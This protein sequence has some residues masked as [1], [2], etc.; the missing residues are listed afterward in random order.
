MVGKR[1]KDKP[2]QSQS[3]PLTHF[4]QASIG[5]SGHCPGGHLL[6]LQIENG[7][8]YMT[9]WGTMSARCSLSFL[10]PQPAPPLGH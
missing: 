7:C 5:S 3:F 10:T 8:V 6:I 9:L 2:N 1:E 4:L